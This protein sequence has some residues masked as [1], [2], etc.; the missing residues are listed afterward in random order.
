M[1][2]TKPILMR[3]HVSRRELTRR[4]EQGR[5]AM[6]VLAAVVV[7]AGGSMRVKRD[8][9]QSL[10]P[11]HHLTVDR[12][13]LTGDLIL[14]SGVEGRD[15]TPTRVPQSELTF[16]EI[17]ER[18]GRKTEAEKPAENVE[19]HSDPDVLASSEGT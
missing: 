2:H 11:G 8:S 16:A 15:T 10:P 18:Y 4:V 19:G 3:K 12:D 7:E 9:Y 13:A 1:A 6:R 5:S 17:Q 14:K